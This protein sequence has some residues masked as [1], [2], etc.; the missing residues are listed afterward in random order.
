M[1]ATIVKE[2]T[3]IPSQANYFQNRFRIS[4]ILGSFI[5]L[6]LPLT[7]LQLSAVP[8]NIKLAVNL[9]FFLVFGL[10]H[11]FL[12]LAIYLQGENLRY[13]SSSPRNKI[14][15][16]YFPVV[17]ALFFFLLSFSSLGRE[18]RVG[19]LPRTADNPSGWLTVAFAL[20]IFIRMADFTHA[21][22]QTFGMFELFKGQSRCQFP[23]W[24]RRADNYF[25]L[26]MAILQLETFL[27]DGMF[28]PKWYVL[29]TMLV[30]V[31]LFI[32]ILVGLSRAFAGSSRLGAPL[33]PSLYF[34][35][36]T[37]AAALVVYRFELYIACL[38]MHYVEYHLIMM[39]RIFNTKLNL[40]AR[41]DRIMKWFREHKLWFYG[42]LAFLAL[43]Y[44]AVPGIL[45]S[46]ELSFDNNIWGLAYLFNGIFM[47][48]YLLE[49]VIWKFG[50]PFYK[51]I[52]TPLYFSPT[53]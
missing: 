13:F 11:F 28:T 1:T 12:T 52:L 19:I 26:F 9:L 44:A 8:N 30:V 15:Y 40:T 18:I 47:I 14:I 37:T 34:L 51:K 36:Q 49:S 24:M 35:F 29:A 50:N 17:I 33:I 3:N 53:R 31:A 6:T 39:P 42:T 2:T 25:F 21:S 48:H 43:W 10:T 45:K 20:A 7:F 38:A 22:R 4:L 27:N 16:Y 32:S 46:F 5:F 23:K 41:P